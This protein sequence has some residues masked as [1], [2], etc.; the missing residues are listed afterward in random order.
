MRSFTHFERMETSDFYKSKNPF[1]LETSLKIK[2]DKKNVSSYTALPT[3]RVQI[4]L[5]Y[6][7]DVCH[8]KCHYARYKNQCFKNAAKDLNFSKE[9]VKHR[10]PGTL[11]Y[12]E[13][14]LRYLYDY[15]SV[16]HEQKRDVTANK[17]RPPSRLKALKKRPHMMKSNV[18]AKP[19]T[20]AAP[21][22]QEESILQAKIDRTLA[23][24]SLQEPFPTISSPYDSP[25]KQTF[26]T[27]LHENLGTLMIQRQSKKFSRDVTI[28]EPEYDYLGWEDKLLKKLNRATAQWIVNNQSSWGGWVQGKILCFKKQKYDWNSIRYVLPSENDVELLNTVQA[29]QEAMECP[30]QHPEEKKP[31][32]PLPLYY[33]S[34]PQFDRGQVGGEGRH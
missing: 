3:I 29:E 27:E 4:P 11:S 30:V 16:I 1:P 22:Y 6:Q 31:E 9:V 23:E 34:V 17:Q 21:F 18:L 14:D 13:C 25:D 24:A 28:Q 5:T 32:T 8:P 15:S 33:R 7:E 19:T 2:V 12:K 26:L 10:G 20:M